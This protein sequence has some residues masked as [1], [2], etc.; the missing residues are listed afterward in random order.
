MSDGHFYFL[1]VLM[2]SL[3]YVGPCGQSN[4]LRTTGQ[5]REERVVSERAQADEWSYAV[6][7]YTH[8]LP[9]QIPV[10]MVTRTA[11]VV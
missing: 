1:K 9:F 11:S 6:F 8:Q 7:L 10:L 2:V 4:R 5:K 3:R